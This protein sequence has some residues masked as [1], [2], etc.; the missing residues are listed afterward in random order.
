MIAW[1]NV[2]AAQIASAIRD[3]EGQLLV[4]HRLPHE[5]VESA[6]QGRDAMTKK[7]S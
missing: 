5:D 3:L 2:W 7:H 4:M 6:V 1:E